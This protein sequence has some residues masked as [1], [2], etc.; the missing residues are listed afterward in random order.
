M[1]TNELNISISYISNFKPLFLFKHL[2]QFNLFS[3]EKKRIHCKN[4]FFFIF[5]LKYYNFNFFKK[6]SIFIKPIKKKKYTL[7]RAPYRHKLSRHQ[8]EFS[9]F[10]IICN[11]KLYFLNNFIINNL[12]QIYKFL[13][14]LKNYFI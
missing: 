13:V 12:Q 4:F 6:S 1:N 8:F 14:F 10:Y 7:L 9:R 11:F 3:I 5:L 2:K